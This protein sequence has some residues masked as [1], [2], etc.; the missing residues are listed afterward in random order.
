MLT[1][2]NL[3]TATLELFLATLS[4]MQAGK[5]R[6]TLEMRVFVNGKE[7]ATRACLI[8]NRVTSGAELQSTKHSGLVLMNADGSFLD[9][10]NATET[11]LQFAGFLISAAR[12]AQNYGYSVHRDP[13][14]PG[15]FLW[16]N[17]QDGRG[18]DISYNS[19]SDAWLDAYLEAEKLRG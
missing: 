3:A 9:K 5:A 17:N 8:M 14:Q 13:D 4:P 7:F 19:A 16:R 18:S 11:G 15:M 12:A 2:D 1:M 10:R 6:K